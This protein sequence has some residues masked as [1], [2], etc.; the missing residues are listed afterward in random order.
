MADFLVQLQVY[1]AVSAGFHSTQLQLTR[2]VLCAEL[3]VSRNLLIRA[4]STNHILL[5]DNVD[6]SVF[7]AHGSV[8]DNVGLLVAK[9]NYEGIL[10][11]EKVS[12]R[13]EA[14]N[15]KI[16]RSFANNFELEG[17]VKAIR[18]HDDRARG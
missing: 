17:A 13:G 12:D 2:E 15:F 16:E 18:V 10:V 14:V 11:G 6:S 1:S 9:T 7:N 8:G 4:R 3:R 5:V